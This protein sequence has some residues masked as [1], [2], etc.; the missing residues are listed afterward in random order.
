MQ[1]PSRAADSGVIHQNVHAVEGAFD[2]LGHRLH[3]TEI[4]D[5]AF[6]DGTPAG[7]V[8]YVFD[9]SRGLFERSADASA[10]YDA[11]AQVSELEGNGSANAASS[12]GYDG[13]L[14]GQRQ[15]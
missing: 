12:T 6:D 14:A 9:G 3:R 1:R 2:A 4:G 13:Y 8:S 11:R 5:I 7:I 10:E 15:V